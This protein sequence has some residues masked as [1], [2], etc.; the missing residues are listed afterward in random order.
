MIIR[1]G[2]NR[3]LFYV[4]LI[5]LLL[6]A[7]RAGVGPVLAQQVERERDDVRITAVTT[8]AFV[9]PSSRNW[10]SPV[11]T[12]LAGSVSSAATIRASS[13]APGGVSR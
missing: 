3:S 10:A 11:R 9:R 8:S 2:A 12:R 1:W 4:A 6:A 7:G 5:G 13:S